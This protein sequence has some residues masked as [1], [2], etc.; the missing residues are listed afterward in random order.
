LLRDSFKEMHPARA[1]PKIQIRDHNMWLKFLEQSQSNGN[2]WAGPDLNARLLEGVRQQT[3]GELLVFDEEN[4]PPKALFFHA[5][6]V[7]NEF[8]GVNVGFGV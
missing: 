1:L 2:R 4:F 7:P 6:T 5:S 8:A 3:S